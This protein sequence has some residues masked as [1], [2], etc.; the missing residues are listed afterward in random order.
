MLN[1]IRNFA[2]T[3]YAVI[4]VGILIVPF[5]LWGMGGA[6]SGGNQNNIAKINNE[7]VSTK[8]FQDHLS[9]S[10]VDVEKIRKNID[11][12]IIEEILSEL[13]SI[14]MLNMEV[15]DANFIISNKVLN[16]KIKKNKN[17]LDENNK[18]SRIKYE[19][20]LLSSNIS[21][22]NFES[23]IRNNEL[24]NN[25]FKYISGGLSSPLFLVNERFKEDTKDITVEYTNLFSSY[26]KKE[27]FTDLEIDKFVEENQD[28]FKEKLISFKYSKITPKNLIGIS[29]FNNLFFEKI[30]D[31]ENELTNSTSF[32]N[33]KSKYNLESNFIENYKIDDVIDKKKFYT[34]I[35]QD[36]VVNEL[37]LLEEN[38]FFILY[39]ITKSDN[40]LP[41]TN[42]SIFKNKVKE[43]LFNKT[44]YE[45]NNKLISE[46]SEKKFNQTNFQE[47]AKNNLAIAKI[48]SIDDK[49]IFTKDSIKYLLTRSKN[50]FSLV[51]DEEKNVYLVKIIEIF[52]K[53]ISKNSEDFTFYKNR[54]NTTITNSIYDTYD[55]YIND[56]YKVKVNEKTLERVKNYFR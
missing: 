19:K 47:I 7:N 38:D 25:L 46:I 30:D 43:M 31:L 50:D 13:I 24:K 48:N 16:K 32:E 35:F 2:K 23:R 8:D 27:D 28:I 51:A 44:K 3:K 34:K 26:K 18:F 10:N 49:Q 12:N 6:F 20:F 39:E 22:A 54:V 41:D 56:K 14:K 4:L 15:K 33:I 17:F 40:S 9:V 55:L 45:F 11:N 42:T 1:N 29:E 5:V 52:Y 53:D 37:T 36:G 21:A